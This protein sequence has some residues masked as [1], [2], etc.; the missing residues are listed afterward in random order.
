MLNGF[1][2]EIFV[3]CGQEI[4]LTVYTILNVDVMT[5]KRDSQL[6]FFFFGAI[7]F[8]RAPVR[9]FCTFK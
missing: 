2:S 9:V 1:L 7:I 6:S 8:F 5:M 3:S 4:L